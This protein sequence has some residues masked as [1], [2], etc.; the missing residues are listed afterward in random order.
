MVINKG[1]SA[2]KVTSRREGPFLHIHTKCIPK[3]LEE[4]ADETTPVYLVSVI[5][6]EAT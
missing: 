1:W 6:K 4:N 5:E 2:I 3:F